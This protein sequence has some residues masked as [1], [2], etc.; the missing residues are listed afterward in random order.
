MSFFVGAHLMNDGACA[1]IVMWQ[2]AKMV[3]EMFDHLALGFRHEAEAGLVAG[4]TRY[5]A[6]GERSREPQRSEHAGASAQFFD[7]SGAPRQM[8]GFLQI[9]R[10]SC[11]ERVST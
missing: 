5:G 7:A 6:D 3:I 2:Q 1:R 9:G 11:R 8:I 10:A 4:E